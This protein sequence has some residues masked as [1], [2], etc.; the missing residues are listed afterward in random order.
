MSAVLPRAAMTCVTVR[1][2]ARLGAISRDWARHTASTYT[3][4][5]GAARGR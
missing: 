1:D 3:M 5:R 4:R 2:L